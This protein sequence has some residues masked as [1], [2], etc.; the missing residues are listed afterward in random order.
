M[1]MAINTQTSGKFRHE[2]VNGRDHLITMMVAIVGD[3]VMNGMLY[4]DEE[5]SA[6]FEQLNQLPAPN[7][8]PKV[9]GHPISAFHP[10]A[11]NANNI[12]AFIAH[13]VKEGKHVIN[14]LWVDTEI[15]AQSDD[16]KELVHRIENGRQVGVSTGLRMQRFIGDGEVDGKAYDSVARNFKFDHVAVLLNEAPAG[17]ETYLLNDDGSLTT[18]EDT[19]VINQKSTLLGQSVLS[20]LGDGDVSENLN[21]PEKVAMDPKPSK[22]DAPAD[23]NV[24]NKDAITVESAIE[25]LE[26]KGMVVNS[27]A[28][29]DDA[30]FFAE[31]K[32][33]IADL[34]ANEKSRLDTLRTEIVANSDLTEE[35]VANMGEAMLIRLVGSFKTNDYSMQ[36]GAAI[37]SS[38]DGEFL[39]S[40]APDYSEAH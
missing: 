5:V 28:E 29:D 13:P 2:R 8:H 23:D 36:G 37:N 33:K 19:Y 22:K 26:A 40:Y 39:D 31:N 38:T 4:P 24:T 18:D 11:I 10:L 21:Q 20:K 12:G 1:R 35:D 3:S 7:G 27:K 16:G 6:S 15:A 17:A 30:K 9:D 25:F 14:E 32:G 34:L